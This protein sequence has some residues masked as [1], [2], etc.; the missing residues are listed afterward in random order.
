[1]TNSYIKTTLKNMLFQRYQK[2][3]LSYEE[4]QKEVLENPK[5]VISSSMI[6]DTWLIDDVVAHLCIPYELGKGKHATHKEKKQKIIDYINKE[7]QK[8]WAQAGIIQA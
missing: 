8:Y 1:M 6:P 3:L 7:L 5:M 2:L 4:V